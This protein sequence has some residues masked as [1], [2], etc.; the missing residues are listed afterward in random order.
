MRP[1]RDRSLRRA[2]QAKQ[3]VGPIDEFPAPQADTADKG[4][5]PQPIYACSRSAA[6]DR[7]GHGVAVRKIASLASAA[8]MVACSATGS[9][10]RPAVKPVPRTVEE[11]VEVLQHHWLDA[12]TLDWILRNP[13]D[14][15]VTTL[16]LP[17]GTAV[18]NRFKLWRGNPDLLA[19]C[20]TDGAEECSGVIVGELWTKVRKDADPIEVKRLD[21][22]FSLV[23]S[24]E[25]RYRGFRSMRIGEILSSLQ[26]QIDAQSASVA[27]RLPEGCSPRVTLRVAGQPRLDCWVLADKSEDGQDPVSVS[28]FFAWFGWRN[29]IEIKHYPPA[30][31]LA[32]DQPCAWPDLPKRSQ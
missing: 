3:G 11:A 18:R 32:F 14:D 15:V 30:L 17:F 29:G 13:A 16:H 20:G 12:K 21:C 1:L 25:I 8:L 6:L 10:P 5:H 7:R 23:E 27:T 4:A 22:Q 26:S 9:T 2:L 24:L 31:E 28:S 19:S